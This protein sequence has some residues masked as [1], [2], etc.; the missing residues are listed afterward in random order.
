MP[1]MSAQ[2]IFVTV[3]CPN[4][5]A[6]PPTPATKIEETVNRFALSLRSTF[7][8]IFRPLTAIKPYRA[9]QTPPITQP[10]ILERKVTNGAMNAETRASAAVT[11]HAADGFAVGRVGAAAEEGAYHR[12]DAVAE[13]RPRKAWID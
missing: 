5:S 1:R 7:C 13:E 8:T 11:S 6:R 4:V 3:I 2:A 10:G 12:T 9:M